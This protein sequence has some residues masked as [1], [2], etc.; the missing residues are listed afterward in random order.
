MTSSKELESQVIEL[1]WYANANSEEHYNVAFMA[2]VNNRDML[3]SAVLLNRM[4]TTQISSANTS[5]QGQTQV[6]K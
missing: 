1:Q 5:N 6:S 3:N 4:K 2:K